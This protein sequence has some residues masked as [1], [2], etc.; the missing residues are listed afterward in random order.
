MRRQVTEYQGALDGCGG[1]EGEGVLVH[2]DGEK[3]E[4]QWHENK[5][6]GQGRCTYAN[7]DVY[8]GTG[9]EHFEGIVC[10]QEVERIR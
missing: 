8:E 9:R 5:K 7:G 3:Y 6:H 4:G 1:A 10:G 2:S